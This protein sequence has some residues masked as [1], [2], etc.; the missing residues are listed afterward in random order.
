MTSA[1]VTLILRGR[2]RFR[3]VGGSIG[4]FVTAVFAGRIPLATRA[5]VV[6]CVRM[7]VGARVCLFTL[8]W[9]MRG[10]TGFR[11]C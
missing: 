1:S 7:A 8:E 2:P 3:P 9:V 6:D 10:V 4:V 11:A 5:S